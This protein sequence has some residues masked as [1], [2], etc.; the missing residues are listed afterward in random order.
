[1]S[2]IETV[3]T[4][5]ND[6]LIVAGALCVLLLV[7]ILWNLL[8]MVIRAKSFITQTQRTYHQLTTYVLEPFKYISHRLADKAEED[9]EEEYE[10]ELPKKKK[11]K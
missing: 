2:W 8:W 1:M 5:S 11:K 7:V 9:D 6:I 10:L 3:V 4:V